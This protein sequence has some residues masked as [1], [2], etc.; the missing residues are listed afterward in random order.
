MGGRAGFGA[1]AIQLAATCFGHLCQALHDLQ[2]HGI[3]KRIKYAFQYEIAGL[4]MF[5]GSHGLI[6]TRNLLLIYCSNTIEQQYLR[7]EEH[8]SEL[9]SLMRI[10][11]AVYCLTKKHQAAR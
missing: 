7:S 3:A 9:Q 8:T 4:R 11:Y 1:S 10:S 2:A 6:L 5:E